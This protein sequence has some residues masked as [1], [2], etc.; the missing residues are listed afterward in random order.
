M[1]IAVSVLRVDKAGI[2]EESKMMEAARIYKAL[3]LPVFTSSSDHLFDKSD[4]LF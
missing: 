2:K 3:G 4:K 1:W